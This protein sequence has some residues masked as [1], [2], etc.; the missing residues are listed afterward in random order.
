M[1]LIN[2]K[3]EGVVWHILVSDDSF[4]RF[5]LQWSIDALLMILY[6]ITTVTV[7]EFHSGLWR[8]PSHVSKSSN[9]HQLRR[10]LAIRNEIFWYNLQIMYS[11]KWRWMAY[12]VTLKTL[13]E[14]YVTWHECH[15]RVTLTWKVQRVHTS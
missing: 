7:T 5:L 11:R 13:I 6:T 12:K 10:K 9:S 2:L 15:G 3:Q 1:F 4:G 8:Y 14:K